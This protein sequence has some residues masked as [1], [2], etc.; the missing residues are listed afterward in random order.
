MRRSALLFVLLLVPLL[1]LAPTLPPLAPTS[2]TD[3]LTVMTYNILHGQACSGGDRSDEVLTRMELAVQGGSGG[4]RG[5][6]DLAPDIL[7]MQ[8]VSQIFREE[9]VTQ[10]QPCLVLGVAPVLGAPPADV[11]HIFPYEHQ[12][13]YLARRLNGVL[14]ARRVEAGGNS[15]RPTSASPYAMRFVRDNPRIAALVPDATTPVDD[16]TVS[17]KNAKSGNVEIGLA[18]ISRFRIQLVAV[19]N[20]PPGLIPGETRALMHATL[21][22]TARGRAYDFY[23]THL[24]VTGG[25]SPHTVAQAANVVEFIAANRRHPDQPAFLL[26]DCN[27][28]PGTVTTLAFAQAGYVDTF[29]AAN[30]GVPGLTGTRQRFTYNCASTPGSRI[31]YVWA[32]P[33]DQ[34]RLPDIV[35]SEV[36]M[37]YAQEIAPGQCLFPSDHNGVI[38]TFD[39]AAIQ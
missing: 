33:D 36:V 15:R 22:D 3:P 23:L 11:T 20:L 13:S 31:D 24:T 2:S 38:T 35:S 18:L 30:P 9:P 28:T 26:C 8:E 16:E 27:A 34:G 5:I 10:N 1:L 25:S 37:D 14:A 6:A 21:R 17:D 29:A 32:I 12:A 39:M 7:G 4:A 19:H